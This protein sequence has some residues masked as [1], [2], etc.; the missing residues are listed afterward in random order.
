MSSVLLVESAQAIHRP[1]NRMKSF[2]KGGENNLR[3]LQ[4]SRAAISFKE[5]FGKIW[6]DMGGLEF[7][8]EQS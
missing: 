5:I 4:A 1:Y 2:R 6:E 7:E 8:N 3:D